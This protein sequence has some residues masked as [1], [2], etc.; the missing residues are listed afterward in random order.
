MLERFVS[1]V[2]RPGNVSV[3]RNHH[4][5][6]GPFRA[7]LVSVAV[8]SWEIVAEANHG[9]VAARNL[10]LFLPQIALLLMLGLQFFP[11]FQQRMH[12]WVAVATVAMPL[13]LSSHPFR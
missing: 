1:L 5:L 7:V 11:L 8:C 2:K 4:L 3:Q 6:A 12:R 9:D 13:F 10:A